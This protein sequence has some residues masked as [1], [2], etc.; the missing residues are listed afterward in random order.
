MR[1]VVAILALVVLVGGLATVKYKQIS[2]LIGFGKQMQKA[3]PPP[4]VVSTATAREQT[5]ESTLSAVGSVAPVK[6]VTISND[7]PG[8][9][10]AI[11][12]ESGAVVKQGQVLVELDS[13]VERAQ[14]AS[15]RARK[16]LALLNAGR[17]RTLVNSAAIPQAQLDTDEAQLKSSGADLGALAAQ[18]D[19]KI[20]RAPFSGKLGIRTVNIGQYLNPGTSLTV[21]EAIDAVYVDFTMPQQRLADLKVGMPIRVTIE[22]AGGLSSDGTIAAIDPTLDATTR[23]LRVR[24][25]VPNKEEKLRPGMFATVAIVLPQRAAVVAVPATAIVHASFGDSV[26]IVEDKKDENGQLVQSADGKQTKV[27]RQQFVRIG[28]ARG[29][30]VA[31][32]DGITAG[33]EVVSAGAF[34]LRNGSGI[35]V[36]NDVVASPQLAPTPP[37]R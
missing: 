28:E 6:G 1:Y 25:S 13:S 30:Y 34:K 37:N 5:W 24:A 18:I 15:A 11:R 17:S 7:A 33:Q 19:R 22:G 31:I 35:V 29:D 32:A 10:V 27:G 16:E 26:F 2:T 21:L 12:F 36:N 3:G 8:V 14:L 20:V 9:V 23:T 4:E